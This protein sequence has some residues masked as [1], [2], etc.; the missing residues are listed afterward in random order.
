MKKR[1]HGLAG[2]GL[3]GPMSDIPGIKKDL[4]RKYKNSLEVAEKMVRRGRGDELLPLKITND[5][6]WSAARFLSVACEGMNE[7]TFPYYGS[8]KFTTGDQQRKFRW[9]KKV[10]LPVLVLIGSKEQHADRPVPE[11][12]EAF[13]KQIP[14]KYFSGKIIKGADHGFRKKEKELGKD[15]AVWF[16]WVSR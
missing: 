9:A 2:I 6:F 1:G 14:A 16:L 7:D 15:M 12:M 11:I 4:G 13:R 8:T 5:R 10:R 3:L